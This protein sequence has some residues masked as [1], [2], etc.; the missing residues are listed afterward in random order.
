VSVRVATNALKSGPH[1]TLAP[2]GSFPFDLIGAPPS[3]EVDP[4]LWGW[5][6]GERGR[7]QCSFGC[8]T[9]KNQAY[10]F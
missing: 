10:A 9:S 4:D 6:A 5:G 2:I 3:E 8:E 7:G 1:W